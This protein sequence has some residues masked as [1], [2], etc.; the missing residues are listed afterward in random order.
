MIVKNEKKFCRTCKHFMG[1][2]DW[3]LCCDLSHPDYP[4]GFLCYEYT[5]ACERY[6][7]GANV[8][9]SNTLVVN[10]GE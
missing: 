5:K 4:C 6:E 3:D 10:I 7:E 2:G 8:I 1:F 9:S